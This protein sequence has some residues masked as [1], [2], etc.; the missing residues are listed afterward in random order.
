MKE[1]SNLSFKDVASKLG[2][3]DRALDHLLKIY[4]FL[5][6]HKSLRK[7]YLLTSRYKII[8]TEDY[9]WRSFKVKS[10]VDLKVKENYANM[11]FYESIAIALSI[12][13]KAG[14]IN[15]HFAELFT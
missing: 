6:G 14:L 9:E 8:L 7:H 5:L 2:G 11:K 10:K 4:K 13:Y 15:G 12:A 3:E 1:L